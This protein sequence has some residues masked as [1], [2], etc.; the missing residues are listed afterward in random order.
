MASEANAR[1][2]SSFLDYL[3]VEKGS[4]KLTI[5]AYTRDIA[6]FAEFLEKKKRDLISTHR[7]DV[8]NFIQDLFSNQL[9]GRSVGRKGLLGDV[10]GRPLLADSIRITTNDREFPLLTV[11]LTCA[12]KGD[13]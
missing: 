1:V 13:W 5:A 11:P 10:V 8:R 12:V 6:Q 4:A 2:L 3:R 7:D 9:D